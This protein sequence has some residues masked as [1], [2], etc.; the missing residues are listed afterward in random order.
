[1]GTPIVHRLRGRGKKVLLNP[2]TQM[3]TKW[4]TIM[5]M[6]RNL[7]KLRK[8]KRRFVTISRKSV[9]TLIPLLN[10]WT[11]RKKDFLGSFSHE[12]I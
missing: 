2:L 1:M 6:L 12:S 8:L 7:G 10:I 11:F 9:P 4:S 5:K 3:T